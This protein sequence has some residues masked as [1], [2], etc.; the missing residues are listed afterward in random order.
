MNST[1]ETYKNTIAFSAKNSEEWR[2][3]LAENH[4]KESKV[5]LILYNKSSDLESITYDQA[6]DDAICFGWIDS[7]VNKRDEN[8][9]Y[10]YFAKRNPKSN[11]S[12]VNKEKVARLTAENKIMPA[13]QKMIDLAKETGTWVFLDRV[14]NLELPEIMQD[15]FTSNKKAFENWENFPRSIKRGILEWIYNAKKQETQLARITET[16]FLAERNV[17]ANQYIKKLIIKI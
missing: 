3:W 4:D 8:S 10:Q 11:W 6:V 14:E 1:L 16:V 9:R 15:M 17:R 13:G 2:N 7:L 12:K 5:W